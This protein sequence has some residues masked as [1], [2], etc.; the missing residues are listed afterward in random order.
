LKRKLGVTPSLRGISSRQH[1]NGIMLDVGCGGNAQ[2]PDSIP[3]GD[4]NCDILRPVRRI[5]NFVLCDALH[6]PFRNGSFQEVY[7][8]HVIEHVKNPYKM[9]KELVR[10]SALQV[11]IYC[12]HRFHPYRKV[13][14]HKC[15]FTKTWFAQALD[16]LGIYHS[17]R[18]SNFR[19]FPHPFTPFVRLPIE[20]EVHGVISPFGSL[21]SDLSYA[22]HD[23]KVRR[24]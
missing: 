5:P 3:R 15:H 9:L 17:V 24:G 18:Y 12:P 1:D 2:W 8:N 10:V 6:L 4:V 11:H 20:I 7:S 19:Y 21:L 22:H 14:N 13:R 16:K 23:K